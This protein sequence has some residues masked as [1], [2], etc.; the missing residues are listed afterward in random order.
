MSKKEIRKPFR[1]ISLMH[2]HTDNG[3]PG[4]SLTGIDEM[5]TIA[6]KIRADES[7]FP[8]K[9]FCS[10]AY[11]AVES[12]TVLA[13]ELGIPVKSIVRETYLYTQSASAE[14]MRLV[15]SKVLR[16]NAKTVVVISHNPHALALTKY[17]AKNLGHDPENI[18]HTP[19]KTG[20]GWVV[21]EKEYNCFP[22]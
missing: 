3:N 16:C 13:K 8:I 9:L 10:T 18:L 20:S 12:A 21:D 15:G 1:I 19:P 2:G 11:R 7:N 4:L 6:E 5:K 14:T 17:V 22:N